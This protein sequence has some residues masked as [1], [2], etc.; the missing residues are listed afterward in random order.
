MRG[1]YDTDAIDERLAARNGDDMPCRVDTTEMDR[2]ELRELRAELDNVTRMLCEL[3]SQTL[4]LS[5]HSVIEG[6]AEWWAEHQDADARRIERARANGLA[7]LTQE[8]REALGL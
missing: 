2:K 8:E 3:Y 4:G 5:R 6:L 7:K 1:R